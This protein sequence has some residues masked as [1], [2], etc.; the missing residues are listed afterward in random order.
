[1]EIDLVG[2]GLYQAHYLQRRDLRERH[3]LYPYDLRP[4][5]CPEPSPM[6]SRQAVHR[7]AA[8]QM[9]HDRC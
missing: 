4:C 1:M 6:K 8:G 2:V 3:T 7:S 5:R 9:W